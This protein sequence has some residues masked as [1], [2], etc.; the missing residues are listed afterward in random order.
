MQL[1]KVTKADILQKCFSIYIKFLFTFKFNKESNLEIT[2][3]NLKST[4]ISFDLSPIQ[5]R[6]FDL[7]A[8]HDTTYGSILQIR[9]I[10]NELYLYQSKPLILSIKKIQ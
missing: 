7:L 3:F 2:I 4:P 5:L 6:Y 1:T 9:R 10:K 8:A